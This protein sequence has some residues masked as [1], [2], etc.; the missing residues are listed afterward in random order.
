MSRIDGCAD[1]YTSS[2]YRL[3]CSCRPGFVVL[4]VVPNFRTEIIADNLVC[5]SPERPLA[6]SRG[7]SEVMASRREIAEGHPAPFGLM[8]SF[9]EQLARSQASQPKW[10]PHSVVIVG[11]GGGPAKFHSKPT[12]SIFQALRTREKKNSLRPGPYGPKASDRS[13]E[14]LEPVGGASPN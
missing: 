1:R 7:S 4:K 11:E 13:E 5:D 8:G 3:E 12:V 2:R 9:I 10:Y 14:L 6:R